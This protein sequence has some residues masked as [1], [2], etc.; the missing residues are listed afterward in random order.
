[1]R[2]TL[3]HHADHG[4]RF[5]VESD[6]FA[7]DVWIAGEALLPE[8]VAEDGDGRG[9]GSIVFVGEVAA[10][11]RRRAHHF[12]VTGAAHARVE[13]FR[14]ARAGEIHGPAAKGRHRLERLIARAPV[15]E[16]WIRKPAVFHFGPRL[17][18]S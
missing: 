16:V 17:R 4:E 2:K 3:R 7:D 1:M 9:A 15:E 8:A 12:E 5:V 6:L 10:E 11:E 14:F 13:I 18:R